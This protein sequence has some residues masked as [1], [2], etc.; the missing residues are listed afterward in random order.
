ME[1]FCLG[2]DAYKETHHMQYPPEAEVV[3]S[4]LESRGGVAKETMFYG[5]Q[6]I[7]KKHFVGMRVTPEMVAQAKDFCKKVF[8]H[9]Y[10][11]EAGWMHICKKHDGHIPIV[12]KAVPEGLVVPTRNVLM[13]VENTDPEVPFITNFCET[14][15]MQVWYPISV[16]TLSWQIKRLI[17]KYGN[18][19][20][21]CV[22]PFSLNDF[23]YRGV[24]SKESAGIGGSA[25]LVNFLGT[26]TLAGIEHAMEYYQADVCGYS[27]MA[28][29]HSTTTIWG[30]AN[31][32]KAYGH[33]FDQCSEGAILSVVSDSYDIYN[34][35]KNI[36]GVQFHD[37][38]MARGGRLVVRPDSGHP[39]KMSIQCLEMLWE[40]FGGTKNAQGYRVLNPKVGVIYGDW[41][42]YDM[43]KE[44]CEAMMEAGFCVCPENIVFGMGGGLL[45]QVNRDTHKFAFKCS[46]ARIAGEWRGVF[47]QPV[48]DSGKDSKRGRL[49]LI[50]NEFGGGVQTV[51]ESYGGD[52]GYRPGIPADVMREVFRDGQLLADESFDTIR[53]RANAETMNWPLA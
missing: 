19:T 47:K 8:G 13:T 28:T 16:C 18:L 1:N 10:F 22:G 21:G 44:I 50:K 39:P 37:R 4:Y 3:Y 32:D 12:I 15:L 35:V 14:L 5:L 29:E 27:V 6:A 30:R 23:G 34:A 17:A 33:F 46:A 45:Q 43:I 40:A 11:N 36:F 52:G 26:D 38:I 31:E 48:T 42:A 2:T 49:K 25:H 20:G 51:G 9:E 41:I 53:T 7:L 24:S